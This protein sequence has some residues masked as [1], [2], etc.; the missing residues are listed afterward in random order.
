ME[1]L[2]CDKCGFELTDKEDIDLALL[3]AGSLAGSPK[4]AAAGAAE[5][6]FPASISFP[7]QG[8]MQL[9]KGSERRRFQSAGKIT[10]GD[11]G[12]YAGQNP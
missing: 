6:S 10:R 8:E 11:G 12:N 5:V 9:V 4:N 3:K 1:K 2:V 7:V